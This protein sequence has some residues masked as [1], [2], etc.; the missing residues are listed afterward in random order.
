MKIHGR[1]KRIDSAMVSS[2]CKKMG[3]LE[4]IYTCLSNLV[5]ALVESGESGALPEHLLRYA[6]DS[7]KNSVCYRMTQ[8][9]VMPRLEAVT[10][11]AL[12]VHE[13]A[14]ELQGG[15][16]EYHMLGRML[17]D[18]TEGGK[19][20]PN[21][22]VG[23]DSLQN[24]SDED[25]TFRRKGG[26]GYQGYVVNLVEDCGELGNIITQYDYAV[27]LRSDIDFGAEV[28]EKL[29]PQEERIVAVTDGAYASDENFQAAA[30]NNMVLVAT[31]LT[32][33]KPPEIINDFQIEN[34]TIQSCPAGHAPVDCEYR[35]D[36]ELYRAHFDKT[37]CENC[38]H[39]EACPVILQKKTALIK[40]TQSAINRAAYAEK[41]TTEEYK[42]Y[43]R[44]RN[45]VEGVPSVLRR[46]YG[47]DRM[48][49]RGLVRSKMWMG[50]KIGAINIKRV[51]T[52]ALGASFA[53]VFEHFIK[54]KFI[55]AAFAG[56][57][58]FCAITA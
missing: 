52:A 26:K 44:K 25:A 31:N 24:P 47:I 35:E 27:N 20:K 58:R 2:G 48:P 11:D 18:Q 21:K 43:A 12:L 36:K 28:I 40:L 51:I 16:D 3:R 56:R 55:A 45:G 15:F 34:G 54:R 33:Q 53:N 30:E 42:S 49:V 17:G 19:L 8:D 23:P 38:R 46:R 29:G 41:L 39:R 22:K 57:R 9:E 14:G 50:F 1:L 5:K 32:G 13:L 10:A 7:N 4:L 37:T 6:E